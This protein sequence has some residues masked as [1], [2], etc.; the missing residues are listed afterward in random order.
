MRMPYTEYKMAVLLV[1]NRLVLRSIRLENPFFFKIK[2]LRG[3]G[4]Q[5]IAIF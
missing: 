1:G 2:V 5:H 4:R 3:S